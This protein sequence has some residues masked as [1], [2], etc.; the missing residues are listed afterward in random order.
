MVGCLWVMHCWLY[1]VL[2][3]LTLLLV[4]TPL[5]PLSHSLLLS[6]LCLSVCLSLFPS[7]PLL[8]S[9]YL[10]HNLGTYFFIK[11]TTVIEI[12]PPVQS[13]RRN[14]VPRLCCQS[15]FSLEVCILVG[16]PLSGYSW[17]KMGVSHPLRHM[18]HTV[19]WSA[20]HLFAFFSL[21][22]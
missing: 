16:I 7:L 2:W 14:S 22:L 5:S 10:C 19:C 18:S 21:T 8:L 6:L 9:M 17:D 4:L 12:F 20:Q 3:W 13:Q 1:T 15:C 11:T